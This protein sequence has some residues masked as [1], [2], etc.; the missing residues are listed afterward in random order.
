MIN[1][2][3]KLKISQWYEL[4]TT[5]C[6]LGK[7]KPKFNTHCVYDI[8]AGYCDLNK[9]QLKEKVTAEVAENKEWYDRLG[10]VYFGWKDVDLNLWLKKQKY[11]NNSP[12]ELC[13]YVLSVL[14]RRHTIIYTT[15]QTMVYN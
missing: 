12:D 8:F 15:Y 4:D 1:E 14:F 5:H 3:E 9:F 13:I 7:K 10:R 6:F 2:Y 11:K